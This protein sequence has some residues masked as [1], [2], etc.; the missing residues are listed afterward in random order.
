ML[1]KL[2]LYIC[3]LQEQ[4]IQFHLQ[5]VQWVPKQCDIGEKCMNRSNQQ[6]FSYLNISIEQIR[7]YE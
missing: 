3:E 5:G 1:E 2:V 7:N 6:S 4:T